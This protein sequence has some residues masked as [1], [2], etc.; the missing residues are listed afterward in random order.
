MDPKL[1]LASASPR[2]KTILEKLKIPFTI[3]P[4]DIDESTRDGETPSQYVERLSIEKAQKISKQFPDAFVIGSDLTCDFD[5]KAIGKAIDND[6]AKS[7][8][9]SFSNRS[10]FG[11]CGWA[12][13]KG[14]I[15]L[16]SGVASTTVTFKKITQKQ[17]SEY[18]DSGRTEGLA[19]AYGI[20]DIGKS[21]LDDF[22]GSY[23]DI[24]GLPIYLIAEFLISYG[25]EIDIDVL[26]KIREEEKIFLLDLLKR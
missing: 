25:F 11:R 24:L 6:D 17:I 1:I 15:V 18:I 2:R 10:H 19:G 3:L 23:Y 7:M 21:F 22:C 8:L 26:S 20:Q 13:L 12:I 5:G 14:S 9:T 16:A 4:A